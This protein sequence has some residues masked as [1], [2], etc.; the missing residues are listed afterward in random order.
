MPNSR[1][2]ASRF[3]FAYMGQVFCSNFAT[4]SQYLSLYVVGRGYGLESVSLLFLL[5]QASKFVFEVPAG[6]ISDRTNR[7]GTGRLGLFGLAAFY[8]LLLNA[9][10]F[11]LLVT[12]FVVKG[13]AQALLSGTFEA[14]FVDGVSESELVKYNS[15]ERFLFYA[16]YGLSALLGGLLTA[17]GLFIVAIG[18]DLCALGLAAV[19]S[20]LLV[21]GGGRRTLEKQGGDVGCKGGL[22]YIKAVAR[23]LV[24]NRVVLALLGI[25][26]AYALTFV[27]L[28][29]F[30]TLILEGGGFS[31]SVS[32]LLIAVQLVISSAFGMLA[33]R[34][35]QRLGDRRVFVTAG[36]AQLVFTGIM[37]LPFVPSWLVPAFYLAGDL[38][39]VVLAPVKY[40]LFQKSIPSEM[41]ATVLSLQSQ[42]VSVGSMCFFAISGVFSGYLGLRGS[43]LLALALTTSIY[44]PCMN[45]SSRALT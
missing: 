24:G 32:G 19:L 17:H 18:F 22:T 42:V 38:S 2:I 35:V 31:A 34:F 28:E 14:I 20:L 13:I 39:Y 43:L 41:R 4:L 5:Y 30:Y 33:P 11:G 29:D 9:S 6:F 7:A 37:L 45:R 27:G 36:L 23:L 25:D 3:V 44:L 15:I 40:S 26:F 21:D 1:S 8:V 10:S 16:A 12:A